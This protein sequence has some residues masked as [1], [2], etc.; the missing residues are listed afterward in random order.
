[1]R[2][3]SILI[4]Y[5]RCSAKG[6]AIFFSPPSARR[7]PDVNGITASI[8]PY[9]PSR[10][11]GVNILT[12][13]RKRWSVLSGNPPRYFNPR[14]DFQECMDTLYR[15]CASVCSLSV[16]VQIVIRRVR[17]A[18]LLSSAYLESTFEEVT[19]DFA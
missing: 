18:N 4:R 2:R 7:S 6:A 12:F 1:M 10:R 16:G 13:E 14:Y 3:I 17:A 5:R 15:V 19:V 11:G 8:A 9:I